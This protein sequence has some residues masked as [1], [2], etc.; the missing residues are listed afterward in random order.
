MAATK[1]GV[2]SGSP[3]FALLP[4][5]ELSPS[6]PADAAV[7]FLHGLGDSGH[8]WSDIVPALGL[9]T[10]LRVR[11]IFP[12]APE[13]PVTLNGGYEMPAWYDLFD[14]DFKGRADIAGARVSRERIEHLIA[15]EVDRG[16]A[17]RRVVL[18]GFSQGGAIAL[19]TALRYPRRL[20]GVAALSAYVIDPEA[21]PREADAANRDLPVFMAHGSH[22]DVVRYEWGEASRR[23]LES[24]GW[25]VEWHEYE[26]GH[27]ASIDEIAALGRFIAR[28]L[29]S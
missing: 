18:G 21:V 12:H 13:L 19:Y 8:G 15:R 1:H 9:P 7:I 2:D 22:D 3:D 4:A 28:V 16:I 11:F 27:E 23:A 6:G 29:A 5:V 26:L 25:T 14:A 24:S 20:A 10:T 17:P